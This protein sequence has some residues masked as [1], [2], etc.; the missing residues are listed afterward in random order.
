[1]EMFPGVTERTLAY[2][3]S[4]LLAK[5]TY[6]K[7]ARFPLHRYPHGQITY[8]VEGRFAWERTVTADM[9]RIT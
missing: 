8:L 6:E 9:G 4:L 1:M 7:G 3:Q 5:L 2:G